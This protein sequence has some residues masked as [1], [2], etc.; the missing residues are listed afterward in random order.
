[1][2]RCKMLGRVSYGRW[3]M[4]AVLVLLIL[5]AQTL[6]RAADGDSP[7]VGPWQ[8]AT[9]WVAG[10]DAGIAP[11]DVP[12]NVVIGPKTIT[13][14]IGTKVLIEMSYT[15][16]PKQTPSALDVQSADGPMLGIFQRKGDELQIRLNDQAKGRPGGF[17][18]PADG[19]LLVLRPYRCAAIYV[20]NADG[21]GLHRVT[22]VSEFTAVGSPEWS[23][24]GKRIAYDAWCGI[25][26]EGGNDAHIFTVDAAGGDPK[27]LG[28]G[29]MPSWSPDGKQLTYSEYAPQRGVWIMNADGSGR[30]LIDSGGWG[31]EWSPTRNAIAYTVQENGGNICVYDVESKQRRK[32][33]DKNYREIRWG[34]SWSPDGEWIAFHGHPAGA[35]DEVAAV[36]VEGEKKG[37]RRSTLAEIGHAPPTIACCE[38]G[39]Q[40][41]VSLQMPGDPVRRLYFLELE[42]DR[43]PRL[44]PGLPDNWTTGDMAWS[45]DGKQVA[46][47]V[48]P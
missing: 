20:M 6:V 25:M 36:S 12:Y 5:S 43:S 14:R 27:D 47:S 11:N 19:M 34:M 32:L 42:E 2:T 24:D 31:S 29:A 17:D 28:P 38:S 13:L 15:I 7:L 41:L 33:L 9:L 3:F 39:K 1:M 23:R 35:P 16:D 26:G 46:F 4:P 30:Q 8:V 18:R 10:N 22:P 48:V 40:V 37:F 45:P 21:S 44:L